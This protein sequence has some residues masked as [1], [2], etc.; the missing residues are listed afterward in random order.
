MI[1]A[2]PLPKSL[3]L[4]SLYL[5]ASDIMKQD[6]KWYAEPTVALSHFFFY[7]QRTLGGLIDQILWTMNT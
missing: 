1:Y 7:V 2:L 5:I 3:A 4:C 6:V